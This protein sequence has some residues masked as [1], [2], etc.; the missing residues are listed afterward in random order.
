[1]QIQYKWEHSRVIVTLV[2]VMTSVAMAPPKPRVGPRTQCNVGWEGAATYRHTPWLMR[3]MKNQP[4][5]TQTRPRFAPQTVNHHGKNGSCLQCRSEGLTADALRALTMVEAQDTAAGAACAAHNMLQPL[6][7]PVDW[8][9]WVS[10][11]AVPS[12]TRVP[13]PLLPPAR[14]SF[15]LPPDV[16][17]PRAP[18]LAA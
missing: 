17:L 12:A 11:H 4:N 15:L 5:H 10:S 1:M 14:H 6:V 16:R 8:L 2:L 18:W 7:R 9:I 13:F 3:K